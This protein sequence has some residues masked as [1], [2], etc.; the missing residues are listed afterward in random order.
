MDI[1]QVLMTPFSWLLKQFCLFFNSYGIALILFSIIVKLVLAP[2]QFKGKKSMIKMNILSAQQKEIQT[3]YANDPNRQNQEIQKL[4]AENGVS[5]MGGCLWSLI[6][7]FVLF[8]LYAIV[9]RPMKYMMG[10]TETAVV[11]VANALGWT[12]AKGSEFIAGAGTN[13]LILSAMFN[14]NNLAAAQNAAGSDSLFL[15]NFNFLGLDLSQIPT[16]KFWENGITWSSVGLFLMVILSA[17]AAV[18]SMLIM[19]KTNAMNQQQEQTAKSQNRVML[20]MQ[21]VLSLWIGFSMPAGMC[22][23]WICNSILTTVQEL[24]F[25]R[26]LKKDYEEAQRAIA[27]QA[28]RSKAAEK[29]RRRAQAEK[30]AAALA[31]KKGGKKK[32]GQ[33]KKKEEDA[34]SGPDKS[35]SRVGMRQYARGRAYDPDRYTL[36]PY[37]DPSKPAKAPPEESAELT[38]EE[39][40][41][42][43]EDV[44]GKAL[45]EQAEA[46]A[47][48]DAEAETPPEDVGGAALGAPSDSTDG[49]DTPSDGAAD[50]P[51]D[52]L[53]S[54]PAAPTFDTPT[55]DKPDFDDD[56]KE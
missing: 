33:A 30:K 21:P 39:K 29:E 42:L 2:F 55:Y 18:I 48:P 23:Y 47:P 40:A 49:P 24:I 38:E 51:S 15:I 37:H 19:T 14:E 27:E 8:P 16:W 3:R 50:A 28:A 22:I 4:Y 5:P 43:A 34:P 54:E 52:S 6:P 17:A 44:Q 46:A 1:W 25:G 53:P 9:R 13:E 11:A 7:V 35:A 10:L 26:V 36:T 32:S 12:A 41:I 56:K 31:E 45:L 20:I